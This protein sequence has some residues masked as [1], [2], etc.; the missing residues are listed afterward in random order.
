[1]SD[2]SEVNNVNV[3][4]NEVTLEI[5]VDNEASNLIFSELLKNGT[6]SSKSISLVNFIDYY[7]FLDADLVDS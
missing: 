7:L 4:N 2:N 3:D 1:M 5:D 6:S